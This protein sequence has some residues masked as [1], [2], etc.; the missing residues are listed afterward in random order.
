MVAE[1]V[2]TREAGEFGKWSHLL[3]NHRQAVESWYDGC[4]VT[5]GWKWFLVE[6]WTV[7]S[8]FE[9]VKCSQVHC[10]SDLVASA[11]QQ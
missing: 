2:G 9:L 8:L 7:L 6:S 1:G 10:G 11:M 5:K 4:S 3:S